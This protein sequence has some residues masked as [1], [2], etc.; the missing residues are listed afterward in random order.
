MA[1][2]PF[3]LEQLV[4]TGAY[5]DLDEPVILTSGELGIYF[6]NTE[7]LLE[8]DGAWQAYADDPMGMAAHMGRVWALRPNVKELLDRLLDRVY[9]VES[10]SDRESA[11]FSGGARRDWPFSTL[12]ALSEGAPHI[13]WFKEGY[14]ILHDG[15][16]FIAELRDAEASPINDS[17]VLHIS[18]LQTKGSSTYNPATSPPSGWVANVW[19]HGGTIYDV[20]TVVDRLQ[21]ARA[22]LERAPESGGKNAVNLHALVEIDDDFLLAA[23]LNPARAL[24][25]RRDDHAWAENYLR[26]HGTSAL[27]DTFDPAGGKQERAVK[28]LKKFESVLAEDDGRRYRELRKSVARRFNYD[29]AG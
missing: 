7:K 9:D 29:L 23:S 18:D 21:G 25:Y 20:F 15:R 3:I 6:I 5:R 16:R 24:E 17:L 14:G 2:D 1:S 4:R 12:A 22:V 19:R 11:L 27:V 28:F 13:A 26:E 8:D 10:A